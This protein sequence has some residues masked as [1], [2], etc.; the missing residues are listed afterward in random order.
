MI[1][2]DFESASWQLGAWET[3]ASLE[4][5]EC[6]DSTQYDLI[7][8]YRGLSF[9][10]LGKIQ[11]AENLIKSVSK[12]MDNKKLAAML[13]SG[14]A[15]SLGR[16]RDLVDGS[17]KSDA[18]QSWYKTSA[19]LALGD[20]ALP[21]LVDKRS[22]S[23]ALLPI[24]FKAPNYQW[25]KSHPEWSKQ[26][27]FNDALGFWHRPAAQSID[28]S[29]GDEI[30]D[31]LLNVVHTSTD[32]S[33]FSKDLI[34]HQTDWP[35]TYHFSADRVNLLRPLAST[36]ASSKVLE[37]GCGCG[38]ITRYLGELGAEVVALEGSLR[39]A[40]IAAARTRD[41]NTVT[42]VADRL[43][44]LPLQGA[45]DVVT[46]IGVLEYSQVFVD[47]ED[48]IQAVLERAKSYLKPSGVLLVAI[49]NQLGLK[50]FAGAPEDHGVGIM[51]GINDLYTD[52]SAI[53]FGHQELKERIQEAGFS[54]VETFL[55]FPDYKL[56]MLVVHPS[57]HKKKIPGWNL[58]T[59]LSNSAPYDKQKIP[60]PTFSLERAWPLVVR[61]GLTADL[62][63]SHLFVASLETSSF[64]D[65]KVLA[66][67]FSPNRAGEY[68]QQIDF[69]VEEKKKITIRRQSLLNTLATLALETKT[70]E[71]YLPGSL[72]S[73]LLHRVIQRPN[74]SLKDILHWCLPWVEALRDHR[75]EPNEMSFN[76]FGTDYREW[77][78]GHFIDAI[79]RNLILQSDGTWSFIDL[80]WVEEQ[81]LPLALVVYRGLVVTLSTLTSISMPEL[82]KFIEPNVLIDK[83]MDELKMSLSEK[84]YFYFMP[85]IERL[86]N[87]AQ[88]QPQPDKMPN[89]PYEFS[90]LKVRKTG[91]PISES[92]N[93][94]L[95]WSIENKGFSEANAVKSSWLLSGGK[96][97]VSLELP[98]LKG[99]FTGL[100]I[101]FTNCPA[102]LLVSSMLLR[103]KADEVI[104]QWD[105]ST[106]ILTQIGQ[107]KI[108]ALDNDHVAFV[109]TGND[110][111]FVLNLPENIYPELA[112]A[113][114]LIS[115]QGGVL[116]N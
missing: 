116:H 54:Q 3:L 66:S 67:Y 79:P 41:L 91:S 102:Y 15:L 64:V 1:L 63:N 94:T 70:P 85:V 60:D 58:G 34:Q 65:K 2:S 61:N 62:A 76:L 37:L 55:P 56:P 14:A 6:C 98:D 110:P 20:L 38:A 12:K 115:I 49:E 59:L 69:V 44:D 92:T 80:E 87:Q 46:L 21:A 75:V 100:R 10:Q 5:N 111:Q 39:R 109:S 96:A 113:V 17:V 82:S 68:S 8:C 25:A 9:F 27:V 88:G 105:F 33:L 103:N 53:T 73:D 40:E 32:V 97:R 99:T 18:A 83:L 106:S 29:D 42:I 72:H 24:E 114:L 74:W 47:A 93:I 23:T 16:A 22:N 77:L 11:E 19:E 108:S 4:S 84:D 28:Y 30:E 36:L 101:D 26:Y 13:L 71:T 35:S 86:S 112:G 51:S 48:P 78:P 45:F 89:N 52:E 43:Q 31:R 104:W 57:G 90:S 7:S 50:Y 107:L 81:P 95:Y